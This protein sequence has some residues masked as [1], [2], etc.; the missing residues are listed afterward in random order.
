MRG[1]AES[2]ANYH[3]YYGDANLI[4][5]EI[6]RYMA[7]TA[8]DIQ[9]A[10]VKYY[11]H[12][13]PRRALLHERERTMNRFTSLPFGRSSRP[14]LPIGAERKVRVDRS[15]APEL[16]LPPPKSYWATTPSTSSKTGSRL[17]VVEN[18]KLPRVSY[19]LTLD[20]DPIFEGARAGYTSMAGIAHAGGY[21]QPEPR[22][23]SMKRWTA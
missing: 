13:Q 21:R 8:E 12:D 3:M 18:H 7:V 10:A 15:Q 22:P 4:N 17:I 11:N 20:V 6:D 23:K 19:R 14:S 1:I 9:A 16:R 5:N 2:L